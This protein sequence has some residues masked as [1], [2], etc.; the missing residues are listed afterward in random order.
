MDATRKRKNPT[1]TD[2]PDSPLVISATP[3]LPVPETIPAAVGFWG[4]KGEYQS[5]SDR[6]DWANK[7]IATDRRQRLV[8]CVMASRSLPIFETRRPGDIRPRTAIEVAERYA[9]GKATDEQRRAAYAAAYASAAAAAA[10]AAY[11]AAAA[12]YAAA[13]ADAADAAYAAE[14]QKQTEDLLE[15]LA[16]G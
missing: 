1:A 15:I 6:K 7:H 3:F 12:A 11:A 16:N 8:A 13:D 4:P 9:E 5:W 10:D 2:S 14:R